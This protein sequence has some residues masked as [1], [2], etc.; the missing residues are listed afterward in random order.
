MKA[1]HH[2]I[3][4]AWICLSPVVAT[5]ACAAGVTLADLDGAIIETSVVY[6]RTGRRGDVI[7]SGTLRDDREIT[8]GPGESLQHVHTMTMSGPG[9]PSV[10]QESGSYRI[11]KPRQTQSL[12]GGEGVWVF[13]SVWVFEFENGTL[14]LYRSRG[15][16]TK[17]EIVF[18]RGTTGIAC[19]MRASFARENGTCRVTK[20]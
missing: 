11:N 16:K 20:H 4:I 12:G 9:G 5:S 15:Y 18:T 3:F 13:E 10:R 6:D 7:V 17:T 1:P 8:I 19:K 14:T 2:L